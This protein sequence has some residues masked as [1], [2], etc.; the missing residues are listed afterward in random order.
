MALDKVT[1]LALIAIARVIVRADYACFDSGFDISVNDKESSKIKATLTVVVPKGQ[2][3]IASADLTKKLDEWRIEPSKTYNF[4][5]VYLGEF[6]E[7]KT[8][9]K[10]VLKEESVPKTYDKPSGENKGS[11]GGSS[12]TKTVESAQCL[13]CSLAFNVYGNKIEEDS[14]ITKDDYDKAYKQIEVDATMEDMLTMAAG[15]KK[16]SI[17]GANKLFEKIPS[18]INQYKFYRNK[19]V[20]VAIN[21]AYNR[22]KGDKVSVLAENISDSV[23][24]SEDKWNPADIWMSDTSDIESKIENASSTGTGST[25]LVLNFNKFLIDQFNDKHLIGVSLKKITGNADL[26]PM[27]LTK[28]REISKVGYGGASF[29]YPTLDTYIDFKSGSNTSIQFR[30]FSGSKGSWQGEVGIKGSSAKHGKIGGGAIWEILK[31]HNVSYSNR[32]DNNQQF[33]ND[34]GNPR[35]QQGIAE[36]IYELL[37]KFPA[38]DRKMKTGNIEKS[39]EISDIV[40]I[41][42]DDPKEKSTKKN[43]NQRWMYTKFLGLTLIDA[44]HGSGISKEKRD[45]IVQ[46]IYLYASSQHTLSGVYYKLT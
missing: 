44:I 6:I 19:G 25:G 43:H 1:E 13:Y 40:N 2:K 9:I 31:S 42:V 32:A 12:N 45:E 5:N 36:D 10:I 3:R 41:T 26:K 34:C 22:I 37:K 38:A 15:W 23:P 14:L 8:R 27:N 18:T 7:D 20:D 28:D 21:G 33:Y 29:N 17:L 35:L 30:N 11:G 24:A 39:Q 46:D 4:L 16:S